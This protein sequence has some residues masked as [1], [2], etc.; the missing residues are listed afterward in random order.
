[1]ALKHNFKL[2]EDMI[3]QLQEVKNETLKKE[4]ELIKTELIIFKLK[5]SF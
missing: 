1:M 3:I 2:S 5:Y 4:T